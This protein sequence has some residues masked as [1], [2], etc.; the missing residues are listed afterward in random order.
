MAGGAGTGSLVDVL[1]GAPL[2]PSA[3]SGASAPA[4]GAAG[5]AAVAAAS[6]GWRPNTRARKTTIERAPVP[7]PR[8]VMPPATRPSPRRKRARNSTRSLS[9]CSRALR[10]DHHRISA[11][12]KSWTLTHHHPLGPPTRAGGATRA[13]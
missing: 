13:C 10:V 7:T 3:P 9:P 8:T 1:E 5:A 2:T 4:A 12:R 11:S 6:S